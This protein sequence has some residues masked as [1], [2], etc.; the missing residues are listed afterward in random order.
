MTGPEPATTPLHHYSRDGRHGDRAG[1]VSLGS[2]GA[3]Q[4]RRPLLRPRLLTP[5]KDLSRMRDA[6]E[7]C[8]YG[9]RVDPNV[10]PDK[11]LR[12]GS[13]ASLSARDGSVGMAANQ[14]PA[15]LAPPEQPTGGRHRPAHRRTAGSPGGGE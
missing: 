6:A 7:H 14:G 2:Y 9:R 13:R 5:C 15:R 4:R 10:D 12:D 11:E 8:P 1:P 3:G